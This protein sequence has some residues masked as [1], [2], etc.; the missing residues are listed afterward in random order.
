[1]VISLL[2]EDEED[3]LGSLPPPRRKAIVT[4]KKSP[5]VEK[6][7]AVVPTHQT[8]QPP[9]VDDEIMDLADDGDC[10]E[11]FPSP[12][13]NLFATINKSVA[14]E[15]LAVVNPIDRT[16]QGYV[17]VDNNTLSAYAQTNK[18]MKF[19]ENRRHGRKLIW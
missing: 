16:T 17:P 12:R 5:A 11:N 18:Y 13:R 3:C 6:P 9:A 4:V 7:T 10:L 15:I 19:D 1:M 2:S 8:T 14:V